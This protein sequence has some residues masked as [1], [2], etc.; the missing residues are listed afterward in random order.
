[1]SPPTIHKSAIVQK[2][3]AFSLILPL[4]PVSQGPASHCSVCGSLSPEPH[5]T[6]DSSGPDE[7][8]KIRTNDIIILLE[9]CSLLKYTSYKIFVSI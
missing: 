8:I 4:F 7:W 1:M 6:P 2:N 3:P 9:V 5:G